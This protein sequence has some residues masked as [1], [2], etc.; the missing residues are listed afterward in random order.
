MEWS[1]TLKS[2]FTHHT[3]VCIIC[4]SLNSAVD[5]VSV[6]YTSTQRAPEKLYKVRLCVMV[7]QFSLKFIEIGTKR[8]TIIG[9][10]IS[11]TL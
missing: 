9:V 6:Q 7:F 2:R 10:R 5:N 1:V 11:L 8:W 4:A 3:N